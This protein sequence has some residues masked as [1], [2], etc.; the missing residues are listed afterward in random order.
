MV[1]VDQNTATRNG[2]ALSV[3]A[4]FRGKKMPFG[5]CLEIGSIPNDTKFV[6]IGCSILGHSDS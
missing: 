4:E 1:C 3:L 5:I 2:E 6:E